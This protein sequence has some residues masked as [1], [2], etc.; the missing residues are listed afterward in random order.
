MVGCGALCFCIFLF[1]FCRRMI[2][3]PNAP[4]LLKSEADNG[5]KYWMGQRCK[6]PILSLLAFVSRSR[7]CGS[8]S[9]LSLS[10]WHGAF[11]HSRWFVPLRNIEWRWN[12]LLL[13]SLWTY[14]IGFYKVSSHS[15]GGIF[16][17]VL[18]FFL[19]GSILRR[20]PLD[21]TTSTPYRWPPQGM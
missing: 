2:D 17:A 15:L 14:V 3:T 6:M 8:P 18:L 1:C 5:M 11:I 16:F 10:P 13:P 12:V 20:H 9:F 4:I 19:Y 21:L 7:I